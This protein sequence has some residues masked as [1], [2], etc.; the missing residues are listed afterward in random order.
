MNHAELNFPGGKAEILYSG[1]SESFDPSIEKT[2]MERG[3]AKQRL[4][5]TQVLA[6]LAC[7][8]FFRTAADQQAFESWYFD[9]L[10][11]IGWFP[12]EHPRSGEAIQVRFEGASIGKLV[13][14]HTQFRYSARDVVLEYLR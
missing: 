8:L 5:N 14:L 9:V 1:Y 10:K 13:P 7:T 2:E 6:K 4:V 11:R 12:M 3:V